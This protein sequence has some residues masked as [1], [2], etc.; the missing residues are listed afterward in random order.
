ML[1]VHPNGI[2]RA[3]YFS[4]LSDSLAMALSK[5]IFH[6]ITAVCNF[7]FNI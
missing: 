4:Y 3:L 1:S 7:F 2:S 6:P 5:N